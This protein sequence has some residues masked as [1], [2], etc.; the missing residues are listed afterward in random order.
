MIG[1]NVKMLIP[2]PYHGEHDVYNLELPAHPGSSV[3]VDVAGLE[4]NL[5]WRPSFKWRHNGTTHSDPL[6]RRLH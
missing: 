5:T 6:D 3:F 1:R 4:A 2:D